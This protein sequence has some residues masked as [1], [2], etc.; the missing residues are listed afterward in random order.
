MGELDDGGDIVL[1]GAYQDTIEFFL[2]NGW[3]ATDHNWQFNKAIGFPVTATEDDHGFKLSVQFHMTDDAQQLRQKISERLAAGKDVKLSIGYALAAAPIFIERKDYARELAKY[4]RPELVQDSLIKAQ[5]F[6]RIRLIPKLKLYEV[7]VV[8]APMLESAMVTSV[9]GLD[10]KGMFQAVM[11]ERTPCYWELTDALYTV[12]TRL[13]RLTE[14]A[15][16]TNAT[17]DANAE[18]D[19][20]LQEFNDAVRQYATQMF[21]AAATDTGLY[22][23][24]SF[25]GGERKEKVAPGAE[26]PFAKHSDM[27]GSAIEEFVARAKNR[28]EFRR[29]EGRVLSA[30]NRTRITEMV[31]MMQALL[32]E[33]EPVDDGKSKEATKV[34]LQFIESQVAQL[35][36]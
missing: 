3:G 15:A 26:Q 12:I 36:A 13:Y 14:D 34:Y 18:L 28:L 24:D 30:R 4:V 2:Q 20:A 32:D 7:S 1:K 22:Y 21:A 6:P 33:T 27:V 10:I 19:V 5:K 31:S 35:S 16:G 25:V 11:D 17:V 29:K 23:Y 9:K 8:V